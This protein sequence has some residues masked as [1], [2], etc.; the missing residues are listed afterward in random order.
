[1]PLDHLGRARRAAIVA[2]CGAALQ[3]DCGSLFGYLTGSMHVM[4]RAQDRLV[5]HA[6]WWPRWLEIDGF[7][8]LRGAWVD[9]VVVAPDV[10]RSGIGTRVMT[11]LREEIGNFDIGALGTERMPFFERLGWERWTGDTDR[12]LHDPVDT[13]MILRTATTPPIGTGMPIKGVDR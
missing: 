13:L 7:D 4:A 11:R 6:C 10:Q 1:M 5:G 2:L 9:A 12:V 8:R 3:A